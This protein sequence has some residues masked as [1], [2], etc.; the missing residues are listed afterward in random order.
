M[1]KSLTQEIGNRPK[2]IIIVQ[3]RIKSSRLPGKVILKVQNEPLIIKLLKRLNLSKEVDKVIL[4]IPR[5]KQDILIKKILIKNKYEFYE[6]D[7]KNT[8]K[9]YYYA[10]KKFKADIIVRITADCPFS[11]PQLI[12]NFLKKFRKSQVDYLSNTLTPTF[13]DGLDIEIFSFKTLSKTFKLAKSKYDKEHVTPY[14]KRN[15]IFSKKNI[16]FKKNLSKLRWT[17][18]QQED[19][20][21][22]NFIFSKFKSNNFSWHEILKLSKKYKNIFKINENIKRNEGSQISEGQK[23][24]NRAKNII[25]GGTMLFS[26]NPDLTLPKKWPAYYSK[27]K[28][29]EIW[30]LEKNKYLDMSFMGVGTNVLG[31]ANNNIDKKIIKSI[32]KSNMSTLNNKYEILLAEKLI[33]IHPWAKMARFTRT[34]GEAN[35]V[36]IRIARAYTKKNNIA[37]CGYHGWHDWYLSSNLNNKKNLDSLLLKN[38]KTLGI[39]KN[40]KGTV[41]PF[42]YNNFNQLKNLIKKHDIGIIK[43]EVARNMRPKNNFLKKVRQLA[44][45]KNIVLIFDECTSGFRGRLGGLHLDY[46]I[47]PDMAIFGK[48]IG[49]GYAINAIIGK[50][51]IMRAAEETFISSTFWTEKIGVVA[52][53]STI[54]EMERIK[55]WKKINSVG[56]KIRKKWNALAKKH[57]IKIVIQGLNSLLSF[58]IN[59]KNW[60][61]YKTYISQE[62]LKHKILS[63]NVFYPCISHNDQKLKLY[64]DALDKTIK[65]IA[66]CEK[67]KL[68]IDNLLEQPVCQSG[69]G[70]LN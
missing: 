61:K 22:I 62:L 37:V 47:Y 15:K 21:V 18:D 56:K 23:L 39:P 70:R 40:L 54:E 51:H 6:G 17:L 65:N 16:S 27:A 5:S 64:F 30:D 60:L 35:A 58:R 67:K 29:C 34:G 43:M 8:L 12:D 2:T 32:K 33:Q 48:A 24:W 28:G 69:F 50:E 42:V 59:S 10:A 45:K 44:D 26:K 52:A 53:L 57:K 11:D 49:N 1:K 13:P 19:F 7:E 46:K 4:A 36:A 9:R 25:P 3:A 38:L 31:Y 68:N 41:H 63:S 14:I 66:L 55:S 20:E